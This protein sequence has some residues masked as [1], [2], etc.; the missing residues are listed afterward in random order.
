MICVPLVL[1]PPCRGAGP[2]QSQLMLSLR[3]LHQPLLQH[4]LLGCSSCLH[5]GKCHMMLP[6]TTT[7]QKAPHA[8]N[9]GHTALPISVVFFKI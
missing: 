3:L 2:E 7:V 1:M 6:S 8:A 4:I 5:A 9:Q